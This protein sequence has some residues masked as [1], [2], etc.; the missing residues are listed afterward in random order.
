MSS[1]MMIT[2]TTQWLADDLLNKPPKQNGCNKT[3]GFRTKLS[4]G[5]GNRFLSLP[6]E[7]YHR[8][9]YPATIGPSTTRDYIPLL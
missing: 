9:L 5:F 3:K 2:E 6:L 8:Y 1:A 4:K 7:P